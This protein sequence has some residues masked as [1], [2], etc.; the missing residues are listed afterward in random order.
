MKN[1][2]KISGL[3]GV[4]LF[5]LTGCGAAAVYNVQ[6]NQ[7]TVKESASS[8]DVYTAIKR[9]G[10]SLGWI[11]TKVKDGEAKATINLRTH[12]AIVRIDYTKTSYSI[13]YENSINLKYD[14]TKNTIHNNYNG[15]VQNLERAID[16][17]LSMFAE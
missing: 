11:V 8:N 6:N 3:V 16:V 15:W 10:V 7:V 5:V 12:R 9:A 2:L 13:N 14:A 17:Q 1:L 4:L